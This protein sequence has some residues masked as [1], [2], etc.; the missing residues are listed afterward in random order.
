MDLNSLNSG[1]AVTKGWLN[2]VCGNIKAQKVSAS[3]FEV[4]D[5]ESNDTVQLSGGIYRRAAGSSP[6]FTVPAVTPPFGAGMVEVATSQANEADVPISALA[7]GCSFELYM[8]GRFID[9]SPAAGG[10]I[11]FYPCFQATQPTD[12]PQAMCELPVDGGAVA[13]LQGFEVRMIFRII[14]TTDT[15]FQ[16]ECSWTTMM[17]LAAAAPSQVRQF[18]NTVT[19]SLTT[20]SRTASVTKRFPFTIWARG[21]SGPFTLTRTQLY[22]RRLS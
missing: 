15:S 7:A 10:T 18:T 12:F 19:G 21:E 2:P 22:L 6:T 17:N 1:T 4:T 5:E 14:S 20:P 11:V 9:Q 8:S 16:F 13:G 3:S